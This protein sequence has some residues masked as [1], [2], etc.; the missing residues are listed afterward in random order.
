VV[1]DDGT[2]ALLGSFRTSCSEPFGPGTELTDGTYT[3]TV[4]EATDTVG[5]AL[6]GGD[7]AAA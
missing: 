2:D 3:L 1:S 6:C 5:N 4:T 7:D